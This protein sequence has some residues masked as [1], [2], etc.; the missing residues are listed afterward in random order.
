MQ[1]Q[2]ESS[3]LYFTAFCRGLIIIVFDNMV[4]IALSFLDKHFSVLKPIRIR[5]LYAT[6]TSCYGAGFE[7]VKIQ[8]GT[9]TYGYLIDVT[10]VINIREIIGTWTGKTIKVF[11]IGFNIAFQT[12]RKSDDPMKK[13]EVYSVLNSL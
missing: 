5:H 3:K 6:I 12:S 11:N 10:V 7:F 1:Y 2:N 4:E 9:T 8:L 13:L